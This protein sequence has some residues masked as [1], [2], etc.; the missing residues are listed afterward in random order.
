MFNESKCETVV[1]KAMR[2]I[3]RRGGIIRTSDA[4]RAGI[5]P[6]T[7]YFLRD[8]GVL[9]RLSRGLYRLA[10]L[11]A[12][13]EPDLVTVAARI[14]R[15]VIC[16]FSALSFHDLTTQIP[17]WVYIALEKGAET[18]RIDYPP[19]K[20]H[21]FSKNAFSLGHERQSIDGVEV[22]IYNPE[23]TLADCFKFRNR[24][25]IDVALEAIKLYKERG[26]SKWDDVLKYARVCRIENV[27]RPY[28]EAIL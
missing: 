17:H 2:I 16:L 18:P 7:L 1:L 6:R 27:I 28:L 4:I 5:H 12:L 24:I 20:V 22:R 19:I 11:P 14:P 25:G 21:R 8:T 23:K 10:D 9:E 13:S 15:A 3:T 26:S